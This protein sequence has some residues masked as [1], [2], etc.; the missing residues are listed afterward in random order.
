MSVSTL[1]QIEQVITLT[2]QDICQACSGELL[3]GAGATLVAAVSTDTRTDLS[4][5]FFV[6]L[7]GEHFDAGE[8]I[9]EA[10]NQG[11]M[12]VVAETGAANRLAAELAGGGRLPDETGAPV[13]IAVADSGRALKRIAS[14]VAERSGAP[15]VAITGSTGKTSTK[16]ILFSLLDSQLNAVA[17]RASFNNDVGVPLTLLDITPETEVAV[18]EMGMQAPGEIAELCSVASPRIAVITNVGPAHLQFA[19]SMENIAR[20]KAEIARDLPREGGLVVPYGEPLL[21]PYISGIEAPRITFG[22]D[23][24]ADIHTVNH[25]RL[26]DG[27]LCC[28]LS[29]LGEELDLCFNFAARHQLLNAMAAIGAY[30][31]LGLPLSAVADAARELHLPSMRGEALQLPGGGILLNDCYN[32]NPL[33]MRSSLEYL[34]LVGAGRR[35]VAVL[36][37][38]GELGPESAG[39]HRQVGAAAA[40]LGIDCLIGV[41]ELAAG[42]I[43]GARKA[44]SGLPD[45]LPDTPEPHHFADR[46]AALSQVPSLIRPGDVVLVK[47]SRFMKLEQLSDLLTGAAA[48][49]A[50][51]QKD[52]GGGTGSPEESR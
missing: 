40:E 3:A 21:E 19:G 15:V 23:P 20:G 25:E 12:G 33:S 29:C 52:P 50:E 49:D 17:S 41:G 38:M 9:G 34:V 47:A 30:R 44:A 6:A 2:A 28:T 1:R 24:A 14:L 31:L 45:R 39:Y 35:T 37:D 43:E 22:F 13:I 8:F 51:D 48:A 36:G 16:D 4:G 42:F 10:L 27:R 46:E 11:A 5:S 7:R 26:E 18:V 32:A